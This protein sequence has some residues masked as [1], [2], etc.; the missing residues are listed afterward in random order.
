MVEPMALGKD[1]FVIDKY[2]R[3][4]FKNALRPYGINPAEAMVLLTLYSKGG[5]MG[6]CVF[7]EIHGDRL[8]KT[9][10]QM[11]RDLQYDKGAMTRIMQSLEKNGLVLRK[12]NPADNRSFIFVATTKADAFKPCLLEILR[13]WNHSLL[14]GIECADAVTAAVSQMSQNAKRA[15][16]EQE[17]GDE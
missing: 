10:E 6:E 4:Y 2:F 5:K 11:I 16:V 17:S 13:R 7:D 8:G 15:T 12:K 1:I 9:Q 14:D 3:I